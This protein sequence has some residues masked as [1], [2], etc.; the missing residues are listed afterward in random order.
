MG[1]KT[2]FSVSNESINLHRGSLSARIH[3]QCHFRLVREN[4]FKCHHGEEIRLKYYAGIE[5]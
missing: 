4:K 1:A 5:F 3:C 2:K